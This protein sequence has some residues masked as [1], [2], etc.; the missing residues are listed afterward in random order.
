[1]RCNQE[2][3]RYP[4]PDIINYLGDPAKPIQKFWPFPRL[5][6]QG[7]FNCPENRRVIHKTVQN[8]QGS[9]ASLPLHCQWQSA[10]ATFQRAGGA[11]TCLHRRL[12][13]YKTTPKPRRVGISAAVMDVHMADQQDQQEP[14]LVPNGE[15]GAAAMEG[16]PPVSCVGSNLESV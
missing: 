11:F 14:V 9:S 8:K 10:T 13:A 15:D 6:A 4:A 7:S 12:P 1:V 2:V 3:G 5:V 16:E